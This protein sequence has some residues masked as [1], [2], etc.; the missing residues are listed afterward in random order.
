MPSF[1]A[2]SLA[3]L[4]TCHDEIQLVCFEVIQHYDFKVLCGVRGEAEQT[5]AFNSGHSTK[6]W[7]ES[8]HNATPPGLSDAV[9]I[10]PWYFVAPHIRWNAER[11]FIYLAGHMMQ[12]AFA[13]GI[14]LRWGGDWDQDHDLYDTN[15]PF[16]LGHFERKG[17]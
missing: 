9:D 15:K 4:A 1:G 14:R 11:D 2:D 6:R 3:K 12:A 10:A 7:P 5:A 17:D 8:K 16:D 13:L